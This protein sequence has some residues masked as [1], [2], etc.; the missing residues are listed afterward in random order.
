MTEILQI[1][2]GS[3]CGRG[4]GSATGDLAVPEPG[5]VPGRSLQSLPTARVAL[6]EDLGSRW[7]MNAFFSGDPQLATGCPSPSPGTPHAAR[8]VR[9]QA[10][11]TRRDGWKDWTSASMW[12][13][14]DGRAMV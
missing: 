2:G 1:L 8:R 10:A 7:G 9:S 4:F 11:P 13:E 3:G 12:G 6:R 14:A 5:I